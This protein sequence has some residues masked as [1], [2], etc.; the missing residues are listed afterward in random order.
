[1]QMF[2]AV[3]LQICVVHQLW[4]A[5]GYHSLQ[6]LDQCMRSDNN[7]RQSAFNPVICTPFFFRCHRTR[8]QFNLDWDIILFEHL[9]YILIMLPCKHPLSVPSLPLITIECR[10]HQRKYR[11]DRLTGT[12]IPCTSL[13]IVFSEPRSFSIS[14][15]TF[16][17][18]TGQFKRQIFQKFLYLRAGLHRII[19]VQTFIF[20]L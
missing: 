11:N 15:Q 17:L 19:I 12:D 18:C 20:L 16:L 5:R 8:K 13:D 4:Q 2:P 3:L 6:P 10:I 9:R 7:F 1:M 14:F